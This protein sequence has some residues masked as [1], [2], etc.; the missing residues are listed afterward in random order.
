MFI[1]LKSLIQVIVNTMQYIDIN[2]SNDFGES[3]ID[4][5]V[6]NK[7]KTFNCCLFLITVHLGRDI[8]SPIHMGLV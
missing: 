4:V 2:G 8:L 7:S 1:F 5:S 6:I 3:N